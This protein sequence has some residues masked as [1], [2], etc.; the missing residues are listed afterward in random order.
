MAID[1]TT[2]I[3]FFTPKKFSF[4]PECFVAMPKK[5]NCKLLLTLVND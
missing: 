3:Y 1:P 2:K 5:F 4:V